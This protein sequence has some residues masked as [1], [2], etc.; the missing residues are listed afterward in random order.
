MRNEACEIVIVAEEL[1]KLLQPLAPPRGCPKEF[2]GVKEIL[3][4]S[5]PGVQIL[6]GTGFFRLPKRPATTPVKMAKAHPNTRVIQAVFRPA[7]QGGTSVAQMD[8]GHAQ[9]RSGVG[10]SRRFRFQFAPLAQ[11]AHRFYQDGM[12]AQRPQLVR[13]LAQ[14]N[15]HAVQRSPGRH[16]A[17]QAQH[18]PQFLDRFARL[19]H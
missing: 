11:A 6:V 16:R 19:M 9:K 8:A 10:W 12:I 5:A 17:R 7:A 1:G 4:A 15:R 14:G 2:Q 18:R 13:R 3:R